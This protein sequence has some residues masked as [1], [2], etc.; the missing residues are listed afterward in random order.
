MN[1][2]RAVL[3]NIRISPQKLNLVAQ[4]I[5]GARASDALA[6]LKFSRK[7]IAA[8]VWK[9]LNSAV[10][11]AENNHGLDPDQLYV[12]EAFVGKGICLKRYRARAKGRGSSIHKPFSRLCISLVE[13]EEPARYTRH[14]S[15]ENVESRAEAETAPSLLTD[16]KTEDNKIENEENLESAE[17]V[18]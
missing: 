1:G 12:D 10:A 14:R 2:V 18:E 5:R 3:K 4:S 8:D 15:N 9:T 13:R 17:A 6:T 11:N 7:R 16:E